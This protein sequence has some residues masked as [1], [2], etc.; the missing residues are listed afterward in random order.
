VVR[1][2]P[3]LRH[4]FALLTHLQFPNMLALAGSLNCATIAEGTEDSAQ[5]TLLKE[6]GVDLFQGFLFSK[7]L[8]LQEFIDFLHSSQHQNL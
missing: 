4:F 2:G 3:N 1:P 7:P 8:T 6:L 5:M